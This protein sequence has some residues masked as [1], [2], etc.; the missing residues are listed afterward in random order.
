MAEILKHRLADFRAATSPSE[1]LAGKPRVLRDSDRELMAVDLRDGYWI[2]FSAN[3][4]NNPETETG[5][6]DWTRVSRIKILQI[7]GGND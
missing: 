2:E 3:H 5:E 1:I 4:P 6:V 7:G